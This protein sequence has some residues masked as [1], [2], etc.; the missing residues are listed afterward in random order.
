MKKRTQFISF[1]LSILLIIST[2]LVPTAVYADEWRDYRSSTTIPGERISQR[3]IDEADILTNEE[4]EKLNQK[5]DEINTEYS[6]DVVIATTDSL[7]GYSAEEFADDCYDYNGFGEDGILFLVSME[8]RDWAISTSGEAINVFTDYRQDMLFNLI[9]TDLGNGNWYAA[10]DKFATQCNL[11]IVSYENNK[12][13]STQSNYGSSTT[14]YQYSNNYNNVTS[15]HNTDIEPVEELSPSDIILSSIIVGV[16]IGLIVAFV[17]KKKNNKK[18]LGNEVGF[19]TESYIDGGVNI[20]DHYDRFVRNEH[21]ERF[22]KTRDD[23]NNH[24]RNTSTTH[25]SSSGRTHGG[26][27]GKF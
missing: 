12:T 10:F 21:S 3:V 11:Q 4:E 13:T 17:K 23:S 2:I 1:I 24:S 20:I 19:S 9:K 18:M 22:V 27:S 16:I 7:E 6:Y 15:N 8:G 26:S 5:L 14:K 25:R